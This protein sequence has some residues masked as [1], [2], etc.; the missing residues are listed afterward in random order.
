MQIKPINAAAG[1]VAFILLGWLSVAAAAPIPSGATV[2]HAG[3][4][5]SAGE[6]FTLQAMAED[7]AGAKTEAMPEAMSK[8]QDMSKAEKPVTSVSVRNTRPR[9]DRHR[10]ARVCLD[11][12]NNLAI[13][14]CAEKYRYR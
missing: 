12:G 4:T 2:N 7:D 10:D 13:H 5:T 14:K 3:E 1:A 6:I 8:E 11:A 9:V